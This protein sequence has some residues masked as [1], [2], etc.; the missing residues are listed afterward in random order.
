M[1]T[2]G[3]PGPRGRSHELQRGRA[4]PG[5]HLDCSEVWGCWGSAKVFSGGGSALKSTWES[6][7]LPV[8]GWE[9]R[10]ESLKSCMEKKG[11]LE[12]EPH[13]VLELLLRLPKAH[14]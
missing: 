11:Q 1:V 4:S 9:M 10:E 14:C 13:F 7:S 5:C 2:R 6:P 3:S 8:G 12:D